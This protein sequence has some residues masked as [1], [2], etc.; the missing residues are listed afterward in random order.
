MDR[1]ANLM[2]DE[3]KSFVT[4]FASVWGILSG[5]MVTFPLLNNLWK[6]VRLP[7]SGPMV[8]PETW[9]MLS[10]TCGIYVVYVIFS[11]RRR[12]ETGIDNRDS[13]KFFVIAMGIALIYLKVL[14]EWPHLD[15]D[16]VIRTGQWQLI[17]SF[18]L[19]VGQ[20]LIG[21]LEPCLYL[22]I[23]SLLTAAF[24]K[25]AVREWAARQSGA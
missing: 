19:G 18:I 8:P 6:I 3:L 25:P 24:T 5:F 9:T 11:N 16:Q 4:Y 20:A 15:M 21:V 14:P 13:V 22:A 17:I 7:S 10:T 12:N 1:F 2:S 23:T